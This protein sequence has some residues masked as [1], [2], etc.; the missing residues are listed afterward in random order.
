MELQPKITFIVKTINYEEIFR[1]IVPDENIGNILNNLRNQTVWIEGVDYPLKDGDEF[2]LYGKEAVRVYNLYIANPTEPNMVLEV[3]QDAGRGSLYFDGSSNIYLNGSNDWAV[4]TGDF[5]VEWFQYQETG[6]AYPRIFAVQPWP[7]TQIGASVEENG[8]NF[9][10]WLPGAEGYGSP[11]SNFINSWS[12]FAITR[13]S[14][15]LYLFKDGDL[16]ASYASSEDVNDNSNDLYIGSTASGDN[17]KGYITNFNFVKGTAL[18]TGNFTPPT[19]PIAADANTKLLLLASSQ[20][21][22][23][24]DSSLSGKTLTNNGVTWSDLNPFS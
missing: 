9:Y 3:K 22:A 11:I 10:A 17:F 15:T 8:S 5:T 23:F 13:S 2:T 20:E 7:N 21:T 18:Y 24:V 14:G 4:G 12:H 1:T 16:L 19:E 6:N